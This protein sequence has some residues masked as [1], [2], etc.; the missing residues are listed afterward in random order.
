MPADDLDAL[1]LGVL[2]A[3]KPSVAR[4]LNLVE[5]RRPGDRAAIAVLLDRL[6][7]E[8]GA[9][10]GH[11][12]GLTGP[13]GVGKSTLASAMAV[14]LRRRGSTVG[15][16]AVDPTSMISGGSLLGDRARMGALSGDDGVFVR[17]YATAGEPGGVTST[18]LASVSVLAAAYE[19]VLV[20]TVGVGQTETDVTMI[21]DTVVLVLQPG[22]GDTLQFLKAGIMEI[23]DVLVVQKADHDEL[24]HRALADLGSA[25]RVVR[26]TRGLGNWD[27]PALATSALHG[28]GVSELVDAV[29]AHRVAIDS[30]LAGRRRD[31]SIA[32]AM[33]EF[34]R[35][36]GRYGVVALGG[37]AALRAAMRRDAAAG[38][39]AFTLAHLASS[40]YLSTSAPGNAPV[41]RPSEK[42]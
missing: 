42:P 14:D 12:V 24:A 11:R 7:R 2:R 21:V 13:P 33:H 22:S 16:V 5:S 3:D 8:S 23:P 35:E 28:R 26:S 37:D 4:A 32:W 15:I 38:A 19:T 25:L 31:G 27:T 18:A 17:S 1:V 10:R 9:T 20:E 34:V 30:I 36:H 41:A 29:A 39:H 6:D 40:R